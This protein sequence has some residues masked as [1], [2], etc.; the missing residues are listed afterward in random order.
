MPDEQPVINVASAIAWS[1]TTSGARPRLR[2]RL[3]Q[4][5]HEGR[6]VAEHDDVCRQRFELRKRLAC[7]FGVLVERVDSRGGLAGE[8]ARRGEGVTREQHTFV[9]GQQRAVSARVS[10][11]V[12]DAWPARNLED[13]AVV[14]V[15]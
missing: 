1:L 4:R 12:N 6:T 2:D 10:R 9:L 5:P 11:R 15:L 8:E 3:G 7:P 14:V 13:V